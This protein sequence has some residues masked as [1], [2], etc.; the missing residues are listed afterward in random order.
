MLTLI[1]GPANSG[2]TGKIYSF[3]L[4]SLAKDRKPILILP[5]IPD[6]NRAKHELAKKSGAIIS[7][8]I[9]TFTEFF[10][11][12]T[13]EKKIIPK[14]F[15]GL[16]LKNIISNHNFSVINKSSRFKGFIPE[17]EAA[18]SELIKN[19]ISPSDFKKATSNSKPLK[20][21]NDISVIYYEYRKILDDFNYIDENDLGFAA[22]KKIGKNHYEKHFKH[23]DIY[24]HKFDDFTL[25]QKN[26]IESL[27][28]TKQ[29]NLYITLPFEEGK[30]AFKHNEGIFNWL[31]KITHEKIVLSFDANNYKN[32][33]LH[34]IERNIFEETD[35]KLD[36]ISKV[37]ENPLEILIGAGTVNEVELIG[38]EIIKLIANGYKA[39]EI[40]IIL[41]N[42][43]KY[44][45]ELSLIFDK[46]RIPYSASLIKEKRK[47]PDTDFGNA[48]ISLI[49]AGN[50]YDLLN[51]A[52]SRFSGLSSDDFHR[53]ERSVLTQNSPSLEYVLNIF[54][55]ILP[56][57]PSDLSGCKGEGVV[58][59][60]SEIAKQIF[61]RAYPGG[62]FLFNEQSL[63]DF[64]AF[65]T[66]ITVLKE[67]KN[68]FK[69]FSYLSDDVGLPNIIDILTE[70]PYT[71]P[72]LPEEG[73]VQILTPMRARGRRFK[74]VF[75]MGLNEGNFPSVSSESSFLANEDINLLQKKGFK[76]LKQN[77]S[78][79][80]REMYLF[81]TS[82][83]RAVDK[84]YLC[85]QSSD[86]EGQPKLKSFFIDEV[87]RIFINP[88]VNPKKEK[89]L[90]D[91][92]FKNI[93]D[94]PTRNEQLR[95]IAFFGQKK[96][97]NLPNEIISEL[98]NAKSKSKAH[99]Q[100]INIENNKYKEQYK[101][102]NE[103]SASS[104]ENYFN[105]PYLWFVERVLTPKKFKP[106][107][108][109]LSAGTIAHNVLFEVYDAY[110]DKNKKNESIS[111]SI[112]K[113][114][115]QVD[116]LVNSHKF[117]S[118]SEA[119]NTKHLINLEKIK[120]QVTGLIAD[121]LSTITSFTPI[122]LEVE[123]GSEKEFLPLTFKNGKIRGKIDR[124][125]YCNNNNTA[126]V[127]DYKAKSIYSGR[128]LIDKKA[129]QIILY[130]LA[131]Q[132]IIKKA[133]DKKASVAGG[134]LW[135][136]KSRTKGGIFTQKPDLMEGM[137]ISK[138]SFIE[139][140]EILPDIK[141]IVE[142]IF[143]DIAN[144]LIAT[145]KEQGTDC[146]SY[147]EYEQICRLDK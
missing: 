74:I 80:N 133:I 94:A 57:I 19:N 12:Y 113:I 91:I 105:C 5:T 125:D 111:L 82:I 23:T 100:K 119:E 138:K 140:D 85:Y 77:Q 35:N 11:K 22:L 104:I 103:Y 40:A 132:N 87:E 112:E 121:D 27:S 145:T 79:I 93:M 120:Q 84:A 68:F 124:I 38:S 66:A 83:T 72:G 30:E 114:K 54:R 8:E 41:K 20:F 63:S 56:H 67:L 76:D 122:L 143:E 65:N 106:D 78:N 17:T 48:F 127:Y 135:S 101:K 102:G 18:I 117:E 108:V 47:L 51:F 109:E 97:K 61:G 9:I 64:A 45:P 55:K 3:L 118:L 136:L 1:Y 58:D 146:P 69:E 33:L 25:S 24:I 92:V 39:N 142:K 26:F 43:Q 107:S 141:I 129:I 53:K 89:E 13:S 32:Q 44:L 2:K 139:I 71:L 86:E 60:L 52:R 14:S 29:V 59:C 42:E 37:D 7:C 36:V 50:V 10:K 62:N 128:D 98:N 147:C 116:E 95:S 130:I 49:R 21:L 6:V 81:Y 34:T 46:Y 115:K 99:P 31:L 90:K 126:I 73:F 70:T 88:S 15:K 96:F 137:R 134:L 4:N 144:G 28:L 110:I 123:F 75:I 16:I 131:A